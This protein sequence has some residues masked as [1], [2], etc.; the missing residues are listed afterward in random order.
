MKTSEKKTRI[1]DMVQ[2]PISDAA[3]LFQTPDALNFDDVFD[4]I[5]IPEASEIAQAEAASDQKTF[6]WH[7]ERIY[8]WTGSSIP[9]LMKQGRGK[10]QE[11]GDTALGVILEKFA[12]QCMTE[13]GREEYIYQQ[14]RKEF[15]PCKWGN[16]NEPLAR[17]LYCELMGCEVEVG[18]LTTNPDL[19]IHAGSTDGRVLGEKGIIE[20][21]C[22]FDP[23]K[24]MKN[25]ALTVIDM[26]HEYYGQIQS[27]IES[28][29]ADWCDFVSFDPRQSEPYRIKV[30]R[31]F[32]DQ[33]YIDAMI[34]RIKHADA[35]LQGLK[36]GAGM[37]EA[38]KKI[39]G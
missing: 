24:H 22:P 36:L 4:A 7:L 15:I 32:R 37:D 18:G 29:K 35:I 9:N 23:I 21:K 38:I 28:S 19:P 11:W 34:T 1:K 30:I 26:S 16:E 39:E 31:V 10:G 8:K 25:F 13:E 33:F 12:L 3:T 14:M 20:I 5:K 27:N 2:T 17:A 6:E